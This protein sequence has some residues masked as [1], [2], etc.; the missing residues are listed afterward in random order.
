MARDPH[1]ALVV[2]LCGISFIDISGAQPLV[3]TDR[4]LDRKRLRLA[5]LPPPT[6]FLLDRLSGYFPVIP[7][8]VALPRCRPLTRAT[9]T[10]PAPAPGTHPA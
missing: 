7:D 8:A 4:V 5:C 6:R 10:T 2:D 9:E 1:R 3:D